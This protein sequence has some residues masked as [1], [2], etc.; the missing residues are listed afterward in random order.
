MRRAGAIA[1]LVALGL[2]GLWALDPA[3]PAP[4]AGRLRLATTTSTANSGLLAWLL[5]PF[6]AREGLRVQVI[7]VGTGQA[8]ALGRR[9][10]CDLVMVHARA[11]E[12]A[13]LAAG[14]GVDRRDLMS[15]DFVVLGPRDDP[16]GIRGMEDPGAALARVLERGATFLSRGD[17]SG[18]HLKERALWARVGVDPERRRGYLKAGDG[19]ARCIEVAHQKQ[20]Y[21]LADRGTWLAM[22][23]RPDLAVLVEGHPSLRNPYGVI[24]V[25]PARHPHVNAEG[26]RRLLDWLTSPEGQAR[27]G[28]FRVGGE[29]LFHPLARE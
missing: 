5:A 25:N 10:D 2:A 15:N 12:D 27:I 9:G 26:A 29:V 11:E 13:F 7:A 8:L 23:P 22:A 19:M 3:P 16:A 17:E 20:A 21:V 14:H 6:E 4:A 1:V 18:T 24:L 28:A